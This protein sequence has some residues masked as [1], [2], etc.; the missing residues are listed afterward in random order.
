[1]RCV[2]S[3]VVLLAGM[4]LSVLGGAVVQ[5]RAAQYN[6]LHGFA[7]APTDGAK[8]QF[9]SLATD[10]TTLYGFTFKGGS[11]DKGVLF[12]I[13]PDGIG[14][15]IVHSFTGLSFANVLL[16]GSANPNDGAYPSGTPLL[17]GSTIYGMTQGGGTN[18]T[19]SIFEI[20]TD[21]SGLQVLH[22]FGAGFGPTD[23]Y[24]PYGGLV[25]DGTHL[26]GMTY[27]SMYGRGSI[28]T[29]GKDGNGFTILYNFDASAG[30]AANP[31]G[32]LILSGSTLYGLTLSG[33]ANGLGLI[34]EIQATGLGYHVLHT[35]SCGAND[36]AS[37]Y[38]S[39]IV[40]NSTFYG[41]TS[42]GGANNAG[43]FD[44]QHPKRRLRL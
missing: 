40:S 36:G 8:P 18:G 25:T 16:G 22:S 19:G 1:M 12:Q 10:G 21:G 37:P 17:I 14:Y 3:R 26:Y 6:L 27:S 13:N 44:L 29:I 42:A 28:F 30:Q 32:S 35:F 15:S 39:L 24:S 34:F 20:N 11:A 5:S 2:I 43:T 38:G 4:C 7:G 31:Q 9:G 23:G 41:M 33:G